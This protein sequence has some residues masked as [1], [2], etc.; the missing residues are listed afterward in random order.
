MCAALRT[1][2][3]AFFR[4][5]A[6]VQDF[7]RIADEFGALGGLEHE[8]RGGGGILAEV[9]HQGF[10]G[11]QLNGF[12][13]LVGALD[14]HLSIL[15]FFLFF[16]LHGTGY[17]FPDVNLYGLEREVRALI[18]FGTVIRQDFSREFRIHFRSFQ[19]LGRLIAHGLAGIVFLAVEDAGV[20]DRAGDTGRPVLRVGAQQLLAAIGIGEFQHA[21]EGAF[22]TLHGFQ[23]AGGDNLIGPPA[24]RHLGAELVLLTGLQVQNGSDIVGEGPFGLGV[25]GKAGLKHFLPHQLAV[26]VEVVYA[27]AGGH[28]DGLLYLLFVLYGGQEP[29]GAGRAA[30]VFLAG[31]I[32]YGGIHHGNPL[33]G[34]PGRILQGGH[35]GQVFGCRFFLITGRQ[36]EGHRQ[37]INDSLHHISVCY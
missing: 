21:A 24:G 28:P 6:V 25:M 10:P 30:I 18:D 34:L 29:V 26:H 32:G 8:G 35:Q 19:Q 1:V 23:M 4:A 31:A 20:L 37:T 17:A 22:E 7:G 5:I 16:R 11:I 15:H 12:A 3:T 13:G 14:H 33:G 36:G 27:Q 9:H 2:H